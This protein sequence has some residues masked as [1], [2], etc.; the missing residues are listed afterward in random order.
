VKFQQYDNYP[1][2]TDG[3]A[4]DDIAVAAGGG[5]GGGTAITAESEPNGDSGT[6]DGPV[7]ASVAVS[8]A[9][10][11]SADD[12]WFWFDVT[13]SGTIS[14]SVAI[15]GSAD[16][17]WFLYNSSL[18]QVDRGY[19]TSNPEAGTYNAAPGRYY[20]RVDGY[21]G[22]TSG[23]TLTVGGGLGA[24]DSGVEKQNLPLAWRLGGNEP[25]PFNPTTKIFFDVP[26]TSTVRLRIYDARGQLV[27]TLVNGTLTA[28]QRSAIWDGCDDGGR[29]VTSGVYLYVVE[30]PDFRAARKMTLV[31]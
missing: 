20:L 4:F 2:A 24:S 6:A 25:N 17:D 11:S 12:D 29:P 16:L 9:I 19:T 14:I 5:G 26:R 15:G 28:G 23:Y 30:S 18:T 31:K 3:F 8:G 27:R 1:I 21:N 10:S 7:G 13:T 22:A